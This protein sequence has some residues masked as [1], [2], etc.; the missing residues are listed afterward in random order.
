MEVKEE[1]EDDPLLIHF[2]PL[3]MAKCC[4]LHVLTVEMPPRSLA[5]IY[6]GGLT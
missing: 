2:F 5:S 6:M 3:N 1:F 4:S